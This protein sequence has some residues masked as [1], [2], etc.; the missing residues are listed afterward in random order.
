MINTFAWL[1]N[2]SG[3]VNALLMCVLIIVTAVYVYLTWRL[4]RENI[5]LREDATRPLLAINTSLHEAH[6]HIINLLIQN[7]GGGA[8]HHIR[9]RTLKPF[10]VDRNERLD[11]MGPF[12]KGITYLGP[13]QRHEFFLVNAIGN[14]DELKKQSL[15][16]EA[17]YSD[18][19]GKRYQK[20]FAIDFGELEGISRVGTP[21]LFKVAE[22]IERLEKSFASLLNGMRKLPVLAYSLEDRDREQMVNELWHKFSRLK[23]ADRDEIKKLMDLKL[24]EP[25][26]EETGQAC[27]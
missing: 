17:E 16:I 9:L 22:S 6:I 18:D 26:D 21:P 15:Q 12:K 19:V 20:T 1:N 3:A 2:Y 7:V 25:G 23:P 14:L 8:A 27:S 10:T 13:H 4:V 5:A 11:E 24:G